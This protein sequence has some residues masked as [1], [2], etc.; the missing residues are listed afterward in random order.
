MI[1]LLA[2]CPHDVRSAYPAMPRGQPVGSITVRLSHESQGVT[3]T[4]NGALVAEGRYTK[5]VTVTGVPAGAAQVQVVAG[6]GGHTRVSET[7]VVQVLP[8]TDTA[9][10]VAAP[11][12]TT[13]AWISQGLYS[14]GWWIFMGAVY[15]AI[16]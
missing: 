2:G 7:R 15:A 10:A 6:G 13:G 9:L 1:P 12:V 14:L 5:K 16:L 11:E 8:W 3:V 4:V